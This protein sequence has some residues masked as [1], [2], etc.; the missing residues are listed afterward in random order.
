MANGVVAITELAE[1]INNEIGTQQIARLDIGGGLPVN[2]SV[3][4]SLNLLL[5]R[6]AESTENQK[7]WGNVVNS[8]C[9]SSFLLLHSCVHETYPSTF[10]IFYFQTQGNSA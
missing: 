7:S 4:G 3:G 2:F 1:E 10:Y 9:F 5:Q 8:F 6:H